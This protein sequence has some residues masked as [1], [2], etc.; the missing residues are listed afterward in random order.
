MG[1]EARYTAGARERVLSCLRTTGEISDPGG[2]A[3]AALAK[4]VDYPGSSAAFAQLLSSMERDGLIERSVRGKRT[5]R[6]GL[7]EDT[8]RPLRGGVPAGNPE[9]GGDETPALSPEPD[10]GAAHGRDGQEL[11]PRAGVALDYDELAMRLLEQ[12]VRRIAAA[13]DAGSLAQ[14]ALS[15]A[16]A[17]PAGDPGPRAEDLA[18]T[19]VSLKRRLASIEFRQRELSEEAAMLREELATAQR[20]LAEIQAGFAGGQLDQQERQVL[21]RLLSSLPAAAAR[22]RSAEAG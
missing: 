7:A 1:A 15:T 3:S 8:G 9:P 19:L 5:Y 14:E 17:M 20:S 21:Q 16:R 6:I 2:L 11:R 22:R 4:A 10:P 18:P 13:P 12:V